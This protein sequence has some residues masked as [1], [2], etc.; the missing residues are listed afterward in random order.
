MS[1]L[2]VAIN[3]FGR[4]GR[5]L[6]RLGFEELDI[7][8]INDTCSAE[9]SAHLLK[10][11]SSHGVY[12]KE[13]KAEGNVISVGGKQIHY[14]QIKNPAELPWKQLGVELVL[15]CTGVFKKKEQ[16]MDHIKAGAKKVLVSSPADGA[17]LTIVY[18]I[19]HD[20][21]DPKVHSVVSNASC[22]TNC[23]AP[24]AK[25]LHENFGIVNGVMTTIHSYTNDQRILDQAHS[26]VR[27]ARSAAVSMIP[28]T[29]GAAKAVGLV[30][31][32]LKGKID[33]IA[34]RVPTPNVSLVDLSFNSEKEMT[35]ESINA[36]LK[37]ASETSLKGILAVEEKELVSVDF[38]GNL[39][40]SIVDADCTITMGPKMAKVFSWYDNEA[41]FSQRMIDFARHMQN[42]GL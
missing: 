41:G 36:A 37:K 5:V 28:T 21:Y 17:D 32:Q 18:G 16:F 22:T 20:Q 4:I 34:I 3:G 19:N 9:T 11:D 12:D 25:A 31:P 26:D 8:A 1:K 23:L 24:L 42:K 39:N 13:V 33:G 27:R 15:E 10:Y 38:N 40:S 14:S 6:F 30:L 35:V 7:V 29:T 2:K